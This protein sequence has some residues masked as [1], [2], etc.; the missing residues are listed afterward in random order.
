MQDNVQAQSWSD[1][2]KGRAVTKNG[3]MSV[4]A[5]IESDED[6][7]AFWDDF[8]A[9]IAPNTPFLDLACGAGAVASRAQKSGCSNVTG[10]DVS[11]GAIQA[12]AENCPGAKGIVAPANATGLVDGAYGLIASQFGFEYAGATRVVP[13]VSRLLAPG[14]RFIALCH[15]KGSVIE[16]E[17]AEKRNQI[18]AIIDTGFI[19][20]AKVLFEADKRLGD[21][22]GFA[23]ALD[24]FRPAQDAL[25]AIAKSSGGLAAHLYEGTQTLYSKR[26]NYSLED[27][28]GWL[29]GMANEIVAYYNRMQSMIDVALS[30]S[31]VKS[32]DQA[33]ENYGLSFNG[34]AVFKAGVMQDQLGWVIQASK[35]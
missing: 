18:Q 14:G 10:V 5:G 12:L 8:F 6:I 32:I 16:T 4:G 15:M 17:V 2:W 33:F 23:A 30:E 28:T 13:E 11:E 20:H 31:D 1:Y 22:V 19:E 35:D 24:S 26:L 9:P 27:M 29:D 25:L 7:H 34:A 3:A 21:D